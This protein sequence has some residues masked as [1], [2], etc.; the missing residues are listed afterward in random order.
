MCL[1]NQ[2]NVTL[3][4]VLMVEVLPVEDIARLV[5]NGITRNALILSLMLPIMKK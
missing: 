5:V 3:P 2:L 1:G 4:H